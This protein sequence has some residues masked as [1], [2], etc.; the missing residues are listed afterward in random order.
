MLSVD[1]DSPSSPFKNYNMRME[2]AK[3]LSKEFQAIL[4]GLSNF[5]SAQKSKVETIK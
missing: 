2:N 1:A 5:L 4:K 3:S